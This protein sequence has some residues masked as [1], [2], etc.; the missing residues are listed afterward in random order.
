MSFG[1][2]DLA[3]VLAIVGIF[4]ALLLPVLEQHRAEASRNLCAQKMQFLAF[5]LNDYHEAAEV[6]PPGSS[7][8]ASASPGLLREP[9]PP[10]E[11]GYWSWAYQISPFMGM[12][13]FFDAIDP[14]ESPWWPVFDENFPFDGF[15]AGY[16][17]TPLQCPS[18]PRFPFPLTSAALTSYLGVNGRNQFAEPSAAGQ[19]G[20]IYVNSSVSI[21]EI[22]DGTSNTLILG[23]RPPTGNLN[24]GWAWAGSGGSPS[25][26]FFGTT[27]VTLGVHEWASRPD[28]PDPITFYFQH[29]DLGNTSR[30]HFWS[31]H[32]GGGGNWAFADGSVRF[33]TY[34]V[35][36]AKNETTNPDLQPT[37][38][39]QLATRSKGSSLSIVGE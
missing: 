16:P 3:V 35:D 29:G 27:D 12:Q 15:K 21:N 19:D 20:V 2:I 33:L 26:V 24:W 5:A 23:E 38:L 31:Y 22:T 4:L 34:G 11:S 30:Y 6:F 36:S 9:I 37:I 1:L 39:A 25:L 10:N 13:G 32:A 7:I 17:S 18:D 8:S 14:D 28:T